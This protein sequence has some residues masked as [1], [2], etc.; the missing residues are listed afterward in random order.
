[1]LSGIGRLCNDLAGALLA[2]GYFVCYDVAAV[3]DRL[4]VKENP[5]DEASV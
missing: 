4:S 3:L 2:G 1:M 5:F